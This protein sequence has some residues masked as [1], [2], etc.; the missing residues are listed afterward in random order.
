MASADPPNNDHETTEPPSWL[1]HHLNIEWN[2]DDVDA[3]LTSIDASQDATA[4]TSHALPAELLLLIIEYIPVGYL[5]DI[6]LVCRGFRDAIDGRILYHHL[7]R[8][9]LVVYLV[10][11]NYAAILAISY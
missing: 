11:R 5:L 7:Q 6:R 2:E 4:P 3:L 9:R 10:S 1:A 8:T